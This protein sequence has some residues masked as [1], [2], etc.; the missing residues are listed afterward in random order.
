M[1]I[2]LRFIT[3]SALALLLLPALSFSQAPTLGTAVNFVL[4][5]TNG[6]MTNSG[7]PHLT[8]LTGNVGS[9]LA[10]AIS[11]FGNVD[12]QM[13]DFDAVTG[14]CASDVLSA[15]AQLNGATPTAAH[16]V[17]LGGGETL[18]AGVYH[19]SANAALSSNLIL[20]AQGNPNAVF[21]FQ[22]QGTFSTAT[23]SKVTLINGGLACNVFWKVEGVVSMASGSTMRGTIIAN[24]AAINF[25]AL[26]TLEGRAL[27]IN[28]AVSVGQL[29]AYTP[30]GCGSAVLN[31]PAAPSL[32]STAIFGV[33]SSI[34]TVTGT[35]I[36]YITGDV[37]SNSTTTT[38]FNPLFVTGTI[39]PNPD[40][41]TAAAAGSLTNVYN[42]LVAL[43]V[44]IELL[45]PSNF[46][47]NLILTPHTYHMGAA[48]AFTGNIY[49][50]AENDPN[51]VFVIQ[52]NGTLTTGTTSKVILINGAQAKNVYWKVD[53]AVHIYDNSL[54]NGTL[55]GAGA[56]TLNTGDTLN[57]RVLTIN[58]AIAI[59]G[60]DLNNNPVATCIAAPINGLNTV[61]VSATTVLTD[62]D[63][64]GLWSSSNTAAS[65]GSS[66]GIVTGVLTGSTTITYTS[67]AACVS[68]TTLN[69]NAAPSAITGANTVCT[70]SSISLSDITTGGTWSSGNTA[71]AYVGTGS[72]TVTGVASGLSHIT[73]TLPSGCIA[74]KSITVS[75]ALNPGII[76]G[77]SGV[78]VGSSITLSDAVSGGIWSSSNTSA[79]V[80]GGTITGASSGIDTIR[81]RVASACGTD[82]AIKAIIINSSSNAGTISGLSSVCAGSD[83]ILSDAIVGGSWSASNA[84]A[85]ITGGVLTGAIAG[86]DTIR[87]SV[88][89]GCGLAMTAKIITVNPL[90]N[91]GIISGL[92][93]LCVGSTA[94]LSDAV[95]GGAWSVSNTAA[96]VSAGAVTAVSAGVDT[97]RY[98]VSNL[99]CTA[100]ATKIITVSLSSGAG[101]ITG[102]SSVCIGATVILSDIVAGGTWNSSNATA[103]LLGSIV[104]GIT[105][106][107]DTIR[108]SVVNACGANTVTKILTISP[109]PIVGTIVGA[110]SVCVGL[111]VML[112]DAVT[113]GIW[114]SSSAV[115]TVSGGLVT[116]ISGGID[117]IR[118]EVT[119]L[120][121]VAIAT[122]TVVIDEFQNAGSIAG[123]SSVC[124]GTLVALSDSL[125]GGVWTVSNATAIIFGGLVAGAAAGID[126]VSYT[127]TN[128][129]NSALATHTITVIASPVAGNIS[130]G[131]TVCIGSS[132][133]LSD[134][135]TGGVWNSNN[136]AVAAI[137]ANGTVIGNTPGTVL[138]T[139][140]VVNACGSATATYAMTV[141]SLADCNEGVKAT[142]AMAAELYVYPN[143]NNGA[144]FVRLKS[145]ND[146]SLKIEIRNI[147][148]DKL[149]ELNTTTNI[150]TPVKINFPP[151]LYFLSAS[152]AQGKYTTK[153]IIGK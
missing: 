15:Y 13:H 148:G 6:A 145:A 62:A 60:S 97:I 94:L 12:G 104:T 95:L 43:P 130:G 47:Y 53:G 121:C 48:V 33:F 79:S 25:T 20:D 18:F 129:C 123:P 90:P 45:D 36:T 100:I 119:G 112:S 80:S 126:T 23:G 11:G 86:I 141:L 82:T 118:Y 68:T 50:N 147:V 42:Y 131:L 4:F 142:S 61:C 54:F 56:I 27:S 19:I 127:V 88:N 76:T 153:V 103:I 22:V 46:G 40:A 134:G 144:F 107:T 74:T 55:V 14:T 7:I 32:V 3:L 98:A 149:N 41:T 17:S 70:G 16:A 110:S 81:Y 125:P 34:G 91:A 84:V 101:L 89:N 113:G 51:A 37:G 106:G 26:D 73:Y 72:G 143:P 8:H 114:S 52:I 128:S 71:F 78:C 66:S 152:T 96:T 124:V 87:Y 116:A 44:D 58:G 137:S 69:V 139:Y 38:G 39:H 57:G 28:G 5:T 146:E 49:L 64:G 108:Y 83:I 117:T 35:P 151:G 150:E 77:L 105:A 59:N 102:P 67:P 99:S 92:S 138:I 93:G 85:S 136:T 109:L 115:A 21:I 120:G 1:K 111:S 135:V 122:K 75:A 133:L 9:N 132:L 63:A 24:N 2:N 65:I 31:G 29:M 140:S 30:I 10:A